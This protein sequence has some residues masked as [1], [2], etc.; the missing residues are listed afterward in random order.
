MIIHEGYENLDLVS[1]VVTLGIFDG[2][3]RGHRSLIDA[4]ILQARS[5]KGESVVITFDPHPRLV[6]EQNHERLSFLSTTDEKAGLLRE[7]G[8]DHLI[9]VEFNKSF[10]NMEAC[11][12]V[13]KVLAEKVKTRHLIVGYDHHFGKR[14]EGTFE[15]IKE[16]A[17][18]LN[19]I[20]EQVTG[21]QSSGGVVSSTAI[22][23]ALLEGRL[24]EANNWLGYS[25]PLSGRIVE[26]RKIGRSIGFATANI[27]PDYEYK[28]IPGDGVYAVMVNLDGRSFPGMLS[29]GRNPTVN[30]ENGTRTIE[31]HII[32]FDED[33]YGRE[34]TIEFRKRLRNEIRFDNL[35]QL[36]RQMVLDKEQTLKLLA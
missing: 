16:C 2:V 12:F 7:A 30:K 32:N 35:E 5:D 31:V 1:P 9:I 3:H 25:Y 19:F 23:E 17:Q 13:H 29:I 14:G 36:S 21:L 33:I 18:S 10:S 24:E 20:V 28:L 6:L 4:L 11:E 8:I 34:I 22:R 15:M 27:K 26:G